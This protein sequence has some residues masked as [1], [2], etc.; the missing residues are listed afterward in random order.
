MGKYACRF[1]FPTFLWIPLTCKEHAVRT[2]KWSFLYRKSPFESFAAVNNQVASMLN[3]QLQ[4]IGIL[5]MLL[6]SGLLQ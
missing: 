1:K 6:L 5:E 4:R 3:E 2:Y